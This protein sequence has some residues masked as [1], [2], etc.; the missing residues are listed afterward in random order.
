M[1][2]WQEKTLL[3]Y[4]VASKTKLIQKLGYNHEGWGIE[5][6][7][8]P[9]WLNKIYSKEFVFVVSDGSDNIF[10]Y[11]YPDFKVITKKEL[12]DSSGESIVGI[13]EMEVVNN[14]L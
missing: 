5:I 9:V 3:K 6:A 10:F 4:D 1:L 12:L 14:L 7:K 8:T 2:T 11:S 13:N